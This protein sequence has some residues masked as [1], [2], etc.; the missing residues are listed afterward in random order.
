MSIW[1]DV[2]QVIL[3]KGLVKGDFVTSAG[4]RTDHYYDLRKVMSEPRHLWDIAL[5]M[6]EKIPI[7]KYKSIGC[8]AMGAIPL[9]AAISLI[10]F[11]PY[12]YVR[13]EAKKHGM[14]KKIEGTLQAPCLIIDDV[15]TTGNSISKVLAAIGYKE[16]DFMV[17][18][19]RYNDDK[20]INAL[21]YEKE[22]LK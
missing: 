4:L 18:I 1:E 22:D 14:Q 15:Y 9:V 11:I 3:E 10:R 19:N 2:R 5:L 21:Y 16:A 7:D 20:E 17:V 6:S 12:F 8:M 13:P